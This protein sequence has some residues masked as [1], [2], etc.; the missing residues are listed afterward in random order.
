MQALRAPSLNI[1]TANQTNILVKRKKLSDFVHKIKNNEVNEIVFKPNTNELV[2]IENDGN[3]SVSNYLPSDELWQTII[4]S[5]AEYF[6]DLNE[7]NNFS[8]YMGIAVNLAIIFFILRSL[9]FKPGNMPNPFIS[10]TNIEMEKDIS[11]RFKDVQGIDSAKHELEEIVDFLKNPKK[12]TK[13][14]AKIPKGALLVGQPGTGKTL[15]AR[16]IAGESSVPFIQCSGSTFV[17]MFVGVGAKRVREIFEE[18]R[19]NE[20]CIIFIDEIDAIGKKR[21]MNGFASN[22]EREQTINQLLTEMDGFDDSSQVIVVAA[23]NR[24]DILDDAL[25]RPGRFDRKIQVNYPDLKGRDKILNVHTSNKNLDANVSLEDVAAKTTG[26]TGADLANLMNEAAIKSAKDEG[27]IT[28]DIIDEVYQRI[29]VGAKND[30]IMSP[31][32]KDRIA[33]HEAGHA[34]IG[35]LMQDYDKVSKVS[36]IPRGDAAGITF[37][38]P[39]NDDIKL[40]T[41]DYL[42]SQIRVALAGHAAEELIYGSE[43]VSTGAANDF[44]QVDKIVRDM[45]YKFGFGT[46]LGKIG[47]E[48]SKISEQTAYNVDYEIHQIVETCYNDVK[49]I[50]NKYKLKL[51]Q[52]KDLLVEN[53]TVDGEVVYEIIMSCDI[54]DN[55]KK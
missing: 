25:L 44:I 42:L 16:A 50:L 26:F 28:A 55:K 13:S 29:I 37:F 51:E 30:T 32:M 41:K 11:T 31:R 5:N 24:I 17:E 18:A 48:K 27:I 54:N 49:S 1:A 43:R 15:L 40:Y 7:E 34:I 53:E 20:P 35:A 19:K 39:K 4:Q 45:V 47:T 10:K 2:Y 36:I 3:V 12:Y 14:G 9:T 6:I 38:Q 46:I 21:S 8:T 33:Y 23:T 52:I 22:D